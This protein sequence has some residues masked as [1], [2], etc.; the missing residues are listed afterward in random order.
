MFVAK[1]DKS[2]KCLEWGS[3]Y[4]FRISGGTLASYVHIKFKKHTIV[5]FF[6]CIHAL[7]GEMNS[8]MTLSIDAAGGRVTC[9]KG[10]GLSPGQT[11]WCDFCYGSCQDSG[12]LGPMSSCSKGLDGTTTLPKLSEGTY[13]YHA[14][15]VVD[16]TPAAVVQDAF[17]IRHQG[18]E[19][20][21]FT[22][23]NNNNCTPN[24]TPYYQNRT[25]TWK[26]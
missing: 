9:T 22:K 11:F 1:W 4:I 18:S 19:F 6:T 26:I 12:G 7:P 23:T 17:N 24:K 5:T 3:L 16:Q 15:A 25:C 13:C 8:Y 14:T 20:I 2:D 10:Q 21:C